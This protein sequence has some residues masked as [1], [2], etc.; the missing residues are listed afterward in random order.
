[1]PQS[2]QAFFQQVTRR[3]TWLILVL[4]VLGAAGVAFAK[5]IRDGLAFLIGASVSYA[6]FWAWQRVIDA[7]TPGVKPK[8]SRFYI[9][10]ILLL[11]G[12]A[13]VIIR[14]LGLNVAVAV[15]GLLVSAAAVILE[16]IY[17]LIYART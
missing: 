9:L 11:G 14:F 1:M 2:D 3:L 6:S 13:Y 15:T 12:A 16:L 17:E 8:S 5:G 10:R 7:L 4:G